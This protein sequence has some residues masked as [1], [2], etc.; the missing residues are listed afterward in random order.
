QAFEISLAHDQGVSLVRATIEG[1]I[2]AE[3]G[4]DFTITEVLDGGGTV[5]AVFG[6]SP[7]FEASSLPAGVEHSIA[8]FEFSCGIGGTASAVGLTFADGLGSLARGNSVVVNGQRLVPE[9]EHGFVVCTVGTG[10]LC[11]NGIDDDDDG[12]IDCNDADCIETAECALAHQRDRK[13]T[14]LN[15]SHVKISYAVFCL[16]K[17]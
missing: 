14:R 6:L 10:E 11:D 12:R 13:S 5:G 2:A 4:A 7:P 9:L 3:H 1:T 8:R 16:K 17:K 15:S